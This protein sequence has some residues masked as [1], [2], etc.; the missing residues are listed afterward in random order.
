M[1]FHYRNQTHGVRAEN[2]LNIN[3]LR[4]RKSYPGNNHRHLSENS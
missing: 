3:H 1:M 4:N 2:S